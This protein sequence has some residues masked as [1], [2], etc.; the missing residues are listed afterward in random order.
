MHRRT[1]MFGIANQELAEQTELGLLLALV[2]EERMAW[3]PQVDDRS[4]EP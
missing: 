3:R 4:S 2:Q 1:L